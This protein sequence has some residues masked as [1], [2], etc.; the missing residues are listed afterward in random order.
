M[1]HIVLGVLSVTSFDPRDNLD[2]LN[3]SLSSMDKKTKAQR[4]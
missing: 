4:D 2:T 3:I 1:W